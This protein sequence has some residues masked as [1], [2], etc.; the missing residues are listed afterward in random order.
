MKLNIDK[1]NF[2]DAIDR[3]GDHEITVGHLDNGKNAIMNYIE[4]ISHMREELQ[5]FVDTYD[6]ENPMRTAD[7]H[8][9]D[10]SCVRC[11]RDEIST[12]L[13]KLND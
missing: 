12:I 5:N 1:K 7:M 6:R 4:R 8:H 3:E 10:C 9:L 2:L 11:I 13:G